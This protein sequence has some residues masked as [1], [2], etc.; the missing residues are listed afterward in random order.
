MIGS[1]TKVSL[2]ENREKIVCAMISNNSL[3]TGNVN[4]SARKDE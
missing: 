2:N 4:I 3:W 1:G